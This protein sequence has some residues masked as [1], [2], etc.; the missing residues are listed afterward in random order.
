MGIL[1]IWCDL[2]CVCRSLAKQPAS[3][4]MVVCILAIGM[5]GTTTVF[6]F[7]NGLLLRPLPVPNQERLVDLSERAPKLSLDYA[8]LSYPHFHA[9]RQYNKTFECM[10][11]RTLWW[12]NLSVEGRAER[13]HGLKA[14]HDLFDVLAIRPLL[15]RPFT[16][17]E[18]R[19]GGPDVLL[20]S[21][22]LWERLFARDKEIVGRTLYLDGDSFTIVGVLPPEGAFPEQ[23]DVWLPLRG[24]PEQAQGLGYGLTAGSGI[25]RLKKGVTV[26][27]ARE[28]LTRIHR[29][30]LEQHPDSEPT[31]P[32]VA[33]W[34]ER[35]LGQYRLPMSILLGVAVLLLLIASGNAA[36]II[37]TRAAGR[38]REIATRAA[39][40]ATRR[41]IIQQVLSE[42]LIVSIV[43][44]ALGVLLAHHALGALLAALADSIP[45]WMTFRS[46]IRCILFCLST[47]GVATLLSGLLPA[48]HAAFPK[49]LHGMLQALG[50]RATPSLQRRRALN[51]IVII[52]ISLA[53]TLLIGAGLL[54]QAFRQVQ[55]SD[56]GFRTTGILTYHIPLTAGLYAE[57][58]KRKA[59]WEK[60]LEEVRALPGVARTSLSN[61]LPMTWEELNHFDMEGVLRPGRGEPD[62][63]L[64]TRRV[65]PDY[66]ETLGIRLLSGRF[67]AAQDSEQTAIVNKSFASRFWPG[68][69]PID[70]QIRLR[71]SKEWRHVVG[72]VDDTSD[73]GLDKPAQPVVHL[74]ANLGTSTGMFGV[75]VTSRDP[76]ALV[77]PI[78]EIVQSAD[79][80]LPLEQVRTMSQRVDQSMLLRRLYTWLLGVPAAAAGIIACAGL[81][82]VISYWASQRTREIGIRMTF[83]ARAF[84][85]VVMVIGQGFRLILIGSGFGL[86]GAYAL[87]RALG[88]MGNL[89]YRVS[90]TDPLTFIGVSALLMVVAV[91]ACYL[92]ARRAARIDPMAALRYE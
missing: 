49:D 75:V 84:D 44:G 76:L 16:T 89:L 20:L 92:P 4:L 41:R 19:P 38:S 74:P 23:R 5:A 34:R 61:N 35:Y 69:N 7:F 62:P 90:P 48:L 60:H 82:S 58:S 78:R 47:A 37:L 13:I 31:V 50:N 79:P 9:W 53:L 39:L 73:W 52:Q 3:S 46:D 25:G 63:P 80:G 71:G 81:Y 14:T 24:D 1:S 18:D 68:K 12:A 88:S 59:F 65:T 33:D 21:Y 27:Q 26:E 55:D 32:T 72:V 54:L 43:G 22:G 10:A 77:G 29:A 86:L 42:S 91:P 11:F 36:G 70:R 17:E 57:D 40:G 28:D 64:P 67:F 56:P 6:S 45:V 87:G 2:M 8:D 66:F 15:G 83:G 30:W 85:V 51:T